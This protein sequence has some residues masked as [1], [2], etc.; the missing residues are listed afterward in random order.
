MSFRILHVDDDPH[1]RDIVE[2]SLGLDP[3]LTVTSC[4]S[5]DD[6]LV[7]AADRVP[8]LILCDVMM[9]G[10]D[11]TSIL[12]RLRESAA[13]A[14]TPVVFMTARAQTRELDQLKSLGASAVITKPFD[15][16]KLASTVRGHLRSAK[17]EAASEGFVERLRSDAALLSESRDMLED[18]SG[19]LVVL[20]R[21]ESCVHKLAGASGVLGFDDVSRGASTLEGAIVDRLAGRLTPGTV[22]ASLDAFIRCVYREITRVGRKGTNSGADIAEHVPEVLIADGD[23]AVVGALADRCAS[24][25]FEVRTALNGIQAMIMASQSQP[26]ILI[27]DA[28]MPEANGFDI[29]ARLLDQRCKRIGVVV[30]TGSPNPEMIERCERLGA[31][32]ARKGPDFWNHVVS[33]L[34]EIV[35]DMAAR[36]NELAMRPTCVDVRT[37]PRVLI[38][39]DDPDVDFFLSSRLGKRGVDTLYAADGVQ[40]YRIACQEKPSAIIS[41]YFMPNGDA[42]FLLSKLRSTPGTEN[43]PVFVISGRR[44]DESTER[45]LA[46]EICGRPGA[47]RIFKKSFD[48]DELFGALQEFCGFESNRPAD[49]AVNADLTS[50]SASIWP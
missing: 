14:K 5:V 45:S 37:R 11:G 25:G 48:T 22:E 13:T 27:V 3:T 46:R 21:L 12:A 10:V 33:A 18:D 34:A 20:E 42:R 40:G 50:A 16:M 35:P 17:F 31:F 1:I 30:T 8:D 7:A 6:A 9:P 43:I 39:D 47:A 24:V 2:L 4:G 38:V 29:S 41:D 49:R 26:D 19:S 44:L 28:N 23:P 32:Y 15:P 36:L